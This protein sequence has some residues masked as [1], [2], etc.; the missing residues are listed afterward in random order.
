MLKPL[1]AAM[2]AGGVLVSTA[3]AFSL[4]PSWLKSEDK[5]VVAQAGN[6][7][8][9]TAPAAAAVVPAAPVPMLAPSVPNYRA[10]VKQAGPAVVGVTVEGM[11]KATAE[12]MGLPPG[13]RTIPSFS[14]SAGCLVSRTAVSVATRPFLSKARAR[15][16]SS[17]QTA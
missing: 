14:S 4:V 7:A 15:V 9:N 10:I 17:A 1:T 8:A 6:T 3:G 5:V 11:H 13:P 2:I 12:D 16:S